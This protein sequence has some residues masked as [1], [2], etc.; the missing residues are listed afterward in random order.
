MAIASSFFFWD[1]PSWGEAELWALLFL[2]IPSFFVRRG[3]Q[4]LVV[5]LILGRDG[6]W[7]T[8]KFAVVL[9]TY[10]VLFAFIAILLHTR[11]RG[12]DNIELADQYL[13]LLG[14]PAGG[15]VG[16]AWI[17]QSKE[18]KKRERTGTTPAPANPPKTLEGLGQLISN[19]D[20]NADLLNTQYLAFNVLLVA[21]FLLQFLTGESPKLPELPGT[22][23]GLTGVSAVSYLAKKG[24][25]RDL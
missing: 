13:A 24:L 6:R 4:R 17:R 20:D 21:Y 1:K 14:I 11:G 18:D 15:A 10:A 5:G 7:S 16:A 22:L 8:S 25:E 19:D 23:V 12:L 2:F 9:W 3:G